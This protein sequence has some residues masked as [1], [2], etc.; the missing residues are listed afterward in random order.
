MFQLTPP[1]VLTA[2]GPRGAPF[3][4]ATFQV[5]EFYIE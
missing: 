4:H 5:C 3:I 1:Q 2:A